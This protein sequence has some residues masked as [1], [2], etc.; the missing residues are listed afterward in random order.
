MVAMHF[1]YALQLAY[2][3]TRLPLLIN[4]ILMIALVPMT[5]FLA[6]RYGAVGGAAA[7]AL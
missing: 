3:M 4:S 7:W 1:P 6:L 5:I 2:G